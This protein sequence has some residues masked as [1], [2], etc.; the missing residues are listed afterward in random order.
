ME[1]PSLGVKL[2]VQLPAYARATTMPGP[3]CICDLHHTHGNA[4]SSIHW[5]RLG[6]KPMSSW[7][8]V[9]LISAEP[10]WEPLFS[11]FI[12]SLF[13]ICLTIELGD[14]SYSFNWE[15]FF[16]FFILLRFLWHYEFKRNSCLLWFWRAVFMLK[17]FHVPCGNP[18]FSVQGLFWVWMPAV[19]LLRVCCYRF[20]RQCNWCCG[21]QSLHWILSGTS[22]L[23]GYHS[24]VGDRF[25]SPIVG[26]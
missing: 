1:V 16:C 24:S 26:V 4:E 14:F 23:L 5:V 12:A 18:V 9:G 15:W 11:I 19:S 20:D 21:D 6:I 10:W 3:S 22:L 17:H 25:C 7:F 13:G 2:E 8:L